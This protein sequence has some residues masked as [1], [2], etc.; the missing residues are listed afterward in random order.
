[1]KDPLI[2]QY[3]TIYR[4]K[5]KDNWHLVY[6]PKQKKFIL[7]QGTPQHGMTYHHFSKAEMGRL[8]RQIE[9]LEGLEN[10]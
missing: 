1:M 2:T 8:K 5:I 7:Q 6:A 4:S 10:G 9:E 3:G